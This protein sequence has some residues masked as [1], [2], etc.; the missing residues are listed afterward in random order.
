MA[1]YNVN[2]IEVS[3]FGESPFYG[4]R[5]MSYDMEMEKNHL[6][7]VGQAHPYST[8]YSNKKFTGKVTVIHSEFVNKIQ[9][10]VPKGLS[11]LDLKPFDISIVYMPDHTGIQTTDKWIGVEVTKTAKKFAAGDGV[12]AIEMEVIM[13]N[14][15]E[16]VK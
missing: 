2:R 13:L 15:I 6:H 10:K 3:M 5:E 7:V 12:E 9:E 8:Q 4:I 16:H 11:V 14:V 1:E